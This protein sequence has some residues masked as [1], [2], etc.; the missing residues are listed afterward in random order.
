MI[1]YHLCAYFE[2]YTFARDRKLAIV[3]GHD[4]NNDINSVRAP[5]MG[6]LIIALEKA[7]KQATFRL[8][9]LPAELRQKVYENLLI[10]PE[11]SVVCE[12]SILATS[13]SVYREAVD[14]L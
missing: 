4:T 13:R 11:H 2:L 1:N 14:V 10:F 5:Q 7:D 3:R 12:P 6:E 9:D 8:F